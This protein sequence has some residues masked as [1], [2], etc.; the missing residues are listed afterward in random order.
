MWK[1]VLLAVGVVW[2]LTEREKQSIAISGNRAVTS[3]IDR[4][5]AAAGHIIDQAGPAVGKWLSDLI[6]GGGSSSASS[7][8]TSYSAGVNTSPDYIYWDDV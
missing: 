1:W 4:V 3:T 7:S 5:G 8:A 2:Y 6:S